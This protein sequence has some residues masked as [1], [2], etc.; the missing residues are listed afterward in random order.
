MRAPGLGPLIFL[1]GSVLR[2]FLNQ[3]PEHGVSVCLPY[4]D[5]VQGAGPVWAVIMIPSSPHLLSTTPGQALGS[6]PRTFQY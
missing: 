1:S 6:G 2:K 4:T 3:E 5:S